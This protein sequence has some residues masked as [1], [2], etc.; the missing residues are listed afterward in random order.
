MNFIVS[1]SELL[2]HL[3]SIGK[4]ILSKNTLPILDNFIFKVVGN[5]LT[6]KA[7]DLETTLISKIELQNV[8]GEGE[9]ALDSHRLL[10]I[11]KEFPEQ[12]L[13]FIVN[14]ETLSTE[15]SSDKGKY[16]IV[17]QAADEFPKLA[18]VS[19]EVVKISLNSDVLKQGINKTIF[20]TTN[21][22]MRPVMT[23]IFIELNDN[24]ITFVATDSH[25]LVRYIRT[26]I[27][28]EGNASFILPFKPANLLKSLFT[29]LETEV[30]VLFD[31]KNAFINFEGYSIV[32][33]LIE[34][35]Y[36]NYSTV[37]PDSSPLRIQIDRS[38]FYN[39]LKRVSVFSNQASN[40]VRLK[41]QGNN[42][43]I[44]TEDIDFSISAYERIA[45]TYEGEDIE[46]GFKSLFL[47]E[48]ISNITTKQE[49]YIDLL[50]SS[51]SGIFIPA[52]NDN[53]NEDVLM[54]LMPMM[55]T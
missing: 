48:I 16:N 28:F 50:D 22:D 24:K 19:E 38:E 30:E 44:S 37:I 39:T 53:E 41:I 45:C 46:I 6:I 27:N 4:V 15:I 26:D 23:G 13:T 20:A 34:G 40:L 51:R 1:S 21:D 31:D 14:H 10:D 35:K 11:L 25:K 32:C 9:I 47:L 29:R 42:M 36:P 52:E 2:S 17:G 49:M 43:T 7:S 54:L 12:P 33:R 18:P 5:K 3:Q 8:T 55:L